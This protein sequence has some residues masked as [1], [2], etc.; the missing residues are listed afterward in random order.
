MKLLTKISLYYLLVSLVVFF[1]CG[2]VFFYTFKSEVYEELDE[3]M[4]DERKNI[5]RILKTSESIPE[6]FPAV[7]NEV[8]IKPVHDNYYIKNQRKD[9]IV[10]HVTEGKISLSQW[11]FTVKARNENY[12]VVIRRSLIDLEDLSEQ[13][14]QALLI[15]FFILLFGSL[16]VNY[17]VLKQTFQPFYSAL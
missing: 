8:I 2:L 3:Q 7:N 16:L 11:R 12:L 14:F 13:I 17:V 15:S 9:T 6:F 4:R 1:T 5:E 10:N